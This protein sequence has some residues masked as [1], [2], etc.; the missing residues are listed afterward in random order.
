L[1]AGLPIALLSAGVLRS[2]LYGLQ[3]R[4]PVTFF[5]SLLVVIVVTLAASFLPARQAAAIEPIKALRTE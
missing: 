3:P 2:L 5:A 4:D 1:A